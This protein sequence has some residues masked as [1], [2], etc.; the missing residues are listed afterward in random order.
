MNTSPN[1]R[2]APIRMA[3]QLVGDLEEMTASDLEGLTLRQLLGLV[4]SSLGEAER[5]A[6]LLGSTGDK[7]NGAYDRAVNIGS[8]PIEM[9]VPRSRSGGFRPSLL[10]AKYQRGFAEEM[11]PLL[12]SLLLSSR[13]ISSAKNALRR[14]GLPIPEKELDTVSS[15]LVEEMEL[16][17]TSPISPDMLA[18]FMDGKYVELR[19]ND[20]IRPATIY[21]VVGLGRDGKKRALACIAKPGRENLEDWKKILRSLA[22][23][24]L[25]RVLVVV[26]DDFS[27]L[28]SLNK[29][30]FPTA[31]IQLCIV[32]M[33]RNAKS[34]LPKDDAAEFQKRIRT[35]K[36][37]WNPEVAAK[38]FD[39]L[40]DRF[41]KTAP[42]FVAEIRK[43]RD[44]YLVFLKYPDGIRRSLSTTN[45]VEAV[46]GQLEKIRL[47][48]G[49]YFQSEA[50]LKLK[51]GAA[52]TTLEHTRWAR[53]SA[54]ICEALHQLNVMFQARFEAED[55]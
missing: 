12:L 27:G 29:G 49:G 52:I 25:R 37:A 9:R 16:R 18:I 54:S 11:E 15:Q 44:H 20:R 2:V 24:G 32:H 42:A 31:D 26:Q 55:D 46:N 13:S 1:K 19:D 34:H 53:P 41:A 14:L 38:Q 8:I 51:L 36:A 6:F 43:K 39:D 47:N 7:G 28:L 48:S 10:P 3:D 17:N 5:K 30:L 23:R 45:T 21:L 22:E 35:I 33:Q 40:C 50:V 4:L